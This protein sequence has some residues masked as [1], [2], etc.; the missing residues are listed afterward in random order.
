MQTVIQSHSH[1]FLVLYVVPAVRRTVK[2]VKNLM[3]VN[4]RERM[5]VIQAVLC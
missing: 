1:F 4:E 2:A 3:R 5:V